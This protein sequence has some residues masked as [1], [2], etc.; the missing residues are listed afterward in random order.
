M[1]TKNDAITACSIFIVLFVLFVLFYGS[2]FCVPLKRRNAKINVENDR[3]HQIN[4][5][6]QGLGALGCGEPAKF[7]ANALSLY[8]LATT[9]FVMA[10]HHE[11]VALY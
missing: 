10:G 7:A 8:I 6:T 9:G 2:R 11:L 4:V 3:I 1:S 5:F